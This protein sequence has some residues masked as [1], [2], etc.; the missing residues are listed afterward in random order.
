MMKPGLPRG[1]P[2]HADLPLMK[3]HSA[4]VPIENRGELMVRI[5]Q[6]VFD[7]LRLF[8]IKGY[9]FVIKELAYDPTWVQRTNHNIYLQRLFERLGFVL[10]YLDFDWKT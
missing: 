10:C 1:K 5:H 2:P 6:Y 3:V 7:V 9:R 8:S 4:L